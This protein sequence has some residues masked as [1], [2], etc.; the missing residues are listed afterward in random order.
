M[1]LFTF[2]RLLIIGAFI[3]ASAVVNAAVTPPRPFIER[4]KPDDYY[5]AERAFPEPF[6]RTNELVVLRTTAA[7]PVSVLAL[8]RAE[9]GDGY[10]LTVQL[11][12]SSA[13]DG[14]LKITDDLDSTVGQQVL[15]AVELKLHRQVAL[16]DFKRTMSKTDTDVWV[17]QRL[18]NDRVAAALLSTDAT[19]DNPAAA[20]FLD[21]F[22]GSLERLVGKEGEERSALL[23][24]I[25]RAAT[26]I[27]LAETRGTR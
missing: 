11:A 16:S 21:D 2:L 25:D 13:P 14:W 12:S 27:I 7:K 18:A 5:E 20:A 4:V 10:T 24:K 17:Y 22:L 8:R 1:R 23:Q 26:E 6:S 3:A 15:R 19:I 9:T